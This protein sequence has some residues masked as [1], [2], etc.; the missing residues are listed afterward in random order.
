MINDSNPNVSKAAQ[1]NLTALFN[2]KRHEEI[3]QVIS[4]V[5]KK[6]KEGVITADQKFLGLLSIINE[7]YSDPQPWV[8]TTLK[9]VFAQKNLSANLKQKLKETISSFQKK[10]KQHY[11]IGK[12]QLSESISE[13]V[14]D[15]SNPYTY[16]A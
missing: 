1:S 9:M 14:N 2:I 7:L 4:D 13:R 10:Q 16:F 5:E 3:E 15:F 6:H 11:K 8:E 12:F